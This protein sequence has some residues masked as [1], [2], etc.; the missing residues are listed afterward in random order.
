ML[1]SL[2][3]PAAASRP[4]PAALARCSWF[5]DDGLLRALRFL[6][7]IMQVGACVFCV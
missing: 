3:S 4:G 1:L 5:E 6:E 7:G 2:V